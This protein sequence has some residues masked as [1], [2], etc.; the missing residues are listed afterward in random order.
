MRVIEDGGY[1]DY[2]VTSLGQHEQLLRGVKRG[3]SYTVAV[4][5][6]AA[7]VN[8]SRDVSFV[9]G[10]YRAAT[11]YGSYVILSTYPQCIYILHELI[12]FGKF[13]PMLSCNIV[14]S[15]GYIVRRYPVQMLFRVLKHA[16]PPG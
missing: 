16:R 11:G 6:N 5:V 12:A 9:P 13:A 10:E 7:N 8:W 15:S 4:S 2:H 14:M 1:P 3:A